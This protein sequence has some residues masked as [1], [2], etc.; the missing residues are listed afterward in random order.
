MSD[1]TTLIYALPL[2]PGAR[3]QRW[4]DW[5]DKYQSAWIDAKNWYVAASWFFSNKFDN[6]PY[7]GDWMMVGDP[8][9]QQGR[10]DR[11]SNADLVWRFFQ[12]GK[13]KFRPKL[14]GT[15]AGA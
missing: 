8:A 4:I 10:L 7:R 14:I 11:G 1:S 3:L 13:D 2:E 12:I 5:S 15:V 6:H 9:D